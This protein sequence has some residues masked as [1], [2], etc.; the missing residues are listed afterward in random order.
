[1]VLP[2]ASM[3]VSTSW[4][5]SVEQRGSNT[6]FKASEPMGRK[7]EKLESVIYV[8]HERDFNRGVYADLEKKSTY[9]GPLKY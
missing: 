6:S 4:R 1:M 5:L 2:R 3:M 7:S 8:I 9:Q